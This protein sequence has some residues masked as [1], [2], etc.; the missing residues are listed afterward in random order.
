[1]DVVDNDHAAMVGKE[2]NDSVAIKDSSVSFIVVVLWQPTKK[3]G[4]GSSFFFSKQETTVAT[5]RISPVDF[6]VSTVTIVLL[7]VHRHR[8]T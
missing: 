8:H 2:E 3:S 6:E 4:S 5:R 1:M 7:R